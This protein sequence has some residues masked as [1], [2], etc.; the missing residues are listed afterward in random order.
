MFTQSRSGNAAALRLWSSLQSDRY[1][2]VSERRLVAALVDRDRQHQSLENHPNIAPTLTASMVARSG[3]PFN[4]VATL[5]QVNAS[6]PQLMASLADEDSRM[7]LVRAMDE[8][9]SQA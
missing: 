8:L 3:R 6:A 5:C 2:E 9:L 7:K 1:R 4:V